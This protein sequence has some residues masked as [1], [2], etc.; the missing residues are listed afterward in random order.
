MEKL[1]P[2]PQMHTM[3]FYDPSEDVLSRKRKVV[4]IRGKKAKYEKFVPK[5]SFNID[6][7]SEDI[8]SEGIILGHWKLQFNDIPPEF[9]AGEGYPL[10]NGLGRKEAA[11]FLK[12]KT[13]EDL[14]QYYD[15]ENEEFF[16]LIVYVS[17][18]DADI[19]EFLN[20]AQR[21]NET[22]YEWLDRCGDV[23]LGEI[24]GYKALKEQI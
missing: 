8:K 16:R 10:P 14:S 24:E 18:E 13:I 12:N 11:M 6:I 1:D 20:Y 2:I 4:S 19:K 7:P 22:P 21:E 9:L 17:K 5:Q 23:V 3:A 15:P